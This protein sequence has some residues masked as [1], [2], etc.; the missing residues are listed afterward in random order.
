MSEQVAMG[1]QRSEEKGE[2]LRKTRSGTFQ[3]IT[4]R[5]PMTIDGFQERGYKS[6]SGSPWV[7]KLA[8]LLWWHEVRYAT[9]KG[10]E[11]L[12]LYRA[13]AARQAGLAR[14]ELYREIVMT[15]TGATADE[16]GSLLVQAERSFASWPTVRELTF[17]DVVHYLAVSQY[18]AKEKRKATR[19]DMGRLIAQR[20]PKDL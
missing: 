5:I 6:P 8:F 15:Y 11:L 7:Q 10:R 14:R 2:G 18:L 16:A 19:V 12:T 17:T 9:R 1:S 4:A 20:I 3:R 13:V